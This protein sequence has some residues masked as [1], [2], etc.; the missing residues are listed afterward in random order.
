MMQTR[1]KK[2]I[3]GK[4]VSQK[5]KDT[6]QL[7]QSRRLQ[8][9]RQQLTRKNRRRNRRG[10]KRRSERK[11]RQGVI[12]NIAGAGLRISLSKKRKGKK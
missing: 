5:I 2:Q 1:R 10:R 8:K 7:R 12:D 6:H 11:W 4:I 9:S 3:K